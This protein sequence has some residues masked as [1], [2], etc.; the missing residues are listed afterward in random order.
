MQ[1]TSILIT[2]SFSTFHATDVHLCENHT[3]THLYIYTCCTYAV[4]DKV[5]FIQFDKSL[6]FA[7]TLLRNNG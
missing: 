2:G 6:I 4:V 5:I 7:I 3:S 1:A